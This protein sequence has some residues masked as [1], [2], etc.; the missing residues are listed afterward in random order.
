MSI[1]MHTMQRTFL[2]VSVKSLTACTTMI[3]TTT[4]LTASTTMIHT[5]HTTM[6]HTAHTMV[7][8]TGTNMV[9]KHT[10]S[11]NTLD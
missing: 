5:A 3:T 6:I 11:L 8:T 1:V 10:N 4:I 7:T 9:A 2:R